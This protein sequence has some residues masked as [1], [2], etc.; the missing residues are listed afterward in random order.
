MVK[1]KNSFQLNQEIEEAL[2]KEPA[3]VRK[4]TIK[5]WQDY[6]KGEVVS[7]YE[8]KDIAPPLAKDVDV[9]KNTSKELRA[10]WVS[11]GEKALKKGQ[12]AVYIGEAGQATNFGSCTKAIVE[13]RGDKTFHELKLED[14][15]T[16]QKKYKIQLPIFK[17]VSQE[18][19]KDIAQLE[20]KKKLLKGLK[21]YEILQHLTLRA[22][23]E[24]N[25]LKVGKKL[26]GEI[27]Y[28]VGGHWF[29]FP[30]FREQGLMQAKKLGI[31]FV[32]FSNIDNLGANIYPLLIGYHIWKK[33]QMTMEVADKHKGD[34]GG[35]GARIK[36]KFGL[37]EGPRVPA[38]WQER[39]E[40]TKV[41]KYF[42]TNTFVLSIAAFSC[43]KIPGPMISKKV[44][45]GKEKII[46]ER[47]AG[48]MMLFLKSSILA[49]DRNLR[50]NP[51][52]FITDLWLQRSDWCVLK[53]GQVCP[54]QDEKG[55]Y[56]RK[57]YLKIGESILKSV[58]DLEE[59]I[60]AGG[61]NT[62]LREVKKLVI[63]GP[64]K[65]FDVYGDVR[66]GKNVKFKGDVEI[67]FEGPNSDLII[68]DNAVI[69]DKKIV[70]PEGEHRII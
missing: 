30:E 37:L 58:I 9:L 48:E 6:L 5:D 61:R 2:S 28:A 21:V 19:A 12:V 15:R 69:A 60:A 41:F 44:L 62:S 39:F 45:E 42:N 68:S 40:G 64:K 55:H 29:I 25:A 38:E 34:K 23:P 59:R 16:F 26:S 20:K 52:K 13:V 22:E 1:R 67:I 66:I 11:L 4:L 32:L 33:N 18:T 57:P 56:I 46:F 70:I 8:V 14:V 47:I 31:K 3:W 49:T 51:S 17:F 27:D 53:K 24:Y 36:G 35:V 10:E 54:A 43:K 50:F 63:G 65:K 7:K